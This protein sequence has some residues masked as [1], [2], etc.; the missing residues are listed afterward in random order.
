MSALS[1]RIATIARGPTQAACVEAGSRRAAR[2]VAAGLLATA[3]LFGPLAF[4]AAPRWALGV[5]QLVVGASACIWLGCRTTGKPILWLPILVLG[6]AVCQLLPM[7]LNLL[8]GVS[9]LAY[10]AHVSLQP[11]QI[12]AWHSVS[13]NPGAT[14]AA[15]WQLLLVALVVA[16]VA[17]LGKDPRRQRTLVRAVVLVGGCVFLLGIVFGGRQERLLGI[18]DLRGPIRSWK[19][20]LLSP[21]ESTGFGFS[22]TVRAGAVSYTSIAWDVGDTFGP[23]IVS[24]HFAGCMELTMPLAVGLL[25]GCT[26]GAP[27]RRAC[28][29][30]LAAV[31][32]I[33]V[34][35][36]VGLGASSRAGVGSLLIGMLVTAGLCARRKSARRIWL[37]I[38]GGLFS[39][40]MLLFVWLSDGLPWTTEGLT[41]AASDS[42]QLLERL[43]KDSQE[44]AAIWKIAAATFARSPWM[45]TGLGTYA[46]ASPERGTPPTVPCFAHNDYVQ[47]ASEAGIVGLGI[48]GYAALFWVRRVRAGLPRCLNGPEAGLAAGLMGALTAFLVHSLFDWNLHVPANS[49]LLAV[50]VGLLL[51]MLC[52]NGREAGQATSTRTA[53][54]GPRWV[55]NALILLVLGCGCG[56]AID[57]LAD[58]RMAPLRQAVVAQRVEAKGRLPSVARSTL[59]EMLPHAELASAMAPWSARHAE[60]L[61]QA[62][63]HLSAGRNGPEF[64][65]ARTCFQRALKRCPVNAS[66]RKT[67]DQMEQRLGAHRQQVPQ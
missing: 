22:E 64:L 37:A 61:G 26:A 7:P 46:S 20:P 6:F 60:S 62:Y 18:L 49:L 30:G 24:N 16:M 54:T 43:H 25:L 35:L 11:L 67:L 21:L 47:F 36:L 31:A 50:L 27:T 66:V 33:A 28:R 45:G 15:S 23:Y 40:W 9:P 17:E 12:S 34:L 51:S 52:A 13:V 44:R 5:L 29:F 39:G 59:L 65:A 57:L 41:A 1:D 8:A 55:G 3:V 19:N 14:L 10:A 32:A 42:H 4:G 2:D 56:T 58:R 38:A 63:L 53:G 48:L